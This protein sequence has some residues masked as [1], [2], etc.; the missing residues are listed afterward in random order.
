MIEDLLREDPDDSFTRYAL[1]LE[2]EKE[3]RVEEA[4]LEFQEVATRDPGYVPV[5]YQLGRVL[6]RAGRIDEA[7]EVYAR[8]VQAARSANDDKTRA[9]I[10][11]ALELLD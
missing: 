9:E 10:Q 2:L 4:I 6:A 1:A 5:Y 11:E 8:G 3:E 7:R